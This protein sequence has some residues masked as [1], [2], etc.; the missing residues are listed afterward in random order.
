MDSTGERAGAHDFLRYFC[1][2]IGLRPELSEY[3]NLLTQR[4][5]KIFKYQTKKILLAN[6]QVNDR[7]Y[8]LSQL[9]VECSHASAINYNLNEILDNCF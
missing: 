9:P 3:M 7:D 2:G 8:R 6:F 5:R 1:C 4:Q